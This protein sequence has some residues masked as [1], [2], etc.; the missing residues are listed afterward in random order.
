MKVERG[1]S[2][3]SGALAR[4]C[5]DEGFSRGVHT[6]RSFWY[7][8]VEKGKKM[9]YWNSK[10]WIAKWKCLFISKPSTRKDR[11]KHET[12]STFA[13][14]VSKIAWVSIIRSHAVAHGRNRAL[15]FRNKEWKSE[16]ETRANTVLFI[17][18]TGKSHEDSGAHMPLSKLNENR[19]ARGDTTKWDRDGGNR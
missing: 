2:P 18:K 14:Y 17:Q 10:R 1:R 5:E 7:A 3:R 13:N 6:K 11:G 8:R 16:G 9:S 12:S 15:T 19:K 4:N